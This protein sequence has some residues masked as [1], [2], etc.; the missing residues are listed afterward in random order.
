[1]N[2]FNGKMEM[3]EERVAHLEYRSMEIIPS[4]EEMEKKI[5]FKDE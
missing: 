1:M 3:I 2:K 4:E 5:F